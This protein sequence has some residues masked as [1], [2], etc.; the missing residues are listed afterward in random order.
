MYYIYIYIYFLMPA[1]LK[2]GEKK[3]WSQAAFA[4]EFVPRI[5]LDASA[6]FGEVSLPFISANQ[7]RNPYTVPPSG[8]YVL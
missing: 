4:G 8:V 7:S 1:S 5:D 3:T 2:N 6:V